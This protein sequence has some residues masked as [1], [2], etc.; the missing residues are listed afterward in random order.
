MRRH[1]TIVACLT[2]LASIPSCVGQNLSTALNFQVQSGGNTNYFFRDNTTAAQ[3]LFPNATADF[4]PQRFVAALPAGNSGALVY[5][6]PQ[7]SSTSLSVQAVNGSLSSVIHE[8]NNTGISGRMSFDNNASMGVAVIGAVRAMRDYVEGGGLT[9]VDH[10]LIVARVSV[11]SLLGSHSHEIFN[12]TLG[13]FNSSYFQLHRHN[14]NGT[15]TSDFIMQ[16]DP[17]LN[18]SFSVT[19][20]NNGTWTPPT[21]D[22]LLQANATIGYAD[23]TFLT[24]ETSLVPFGTQDLF[25]QAPPLEA[26][27]ALS[28]A[29]AGLSNGTSSQGTEVCIHYL[30]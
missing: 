7:N 4:G 26:S 3:I 30:I 19:P 18:L 22:F 9:S 24:N 1:S 11:I 21:I 17:S 28:N 23:F 27:P 12:Y 20:G 29:L 10:C 5:F 16:T 25:L 8:L 15:I 13:T 6:L 14:I 2:V